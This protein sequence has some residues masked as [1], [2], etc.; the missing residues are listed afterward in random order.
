VLYFLTLLTLPFSQAQAEKRV[1]LV[2][3]NGRGT[4]MAR[5]RRGRGDQDKRGMERLIRQFG[6]RSAPR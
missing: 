5:I 1:A 6:I 4:G 2:I 3:A